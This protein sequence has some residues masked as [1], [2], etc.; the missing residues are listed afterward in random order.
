M[1]NQGK[2]R[3]LGL[4]LVATSLIVL[5]AINAVQLFNPEKRPSLGIFGSDFKFATGSTECFLPIVVLSFGPRSGL[6][7]RVVDVHFDAEN[8]PASCPRRYRFAANAKPFS[9]ESAL[10]FDWRNETESTI[11]RCPTN[12]GSDGKVVNL[13]DIEIDLSPRLQTGASGCLPIVSFEVTTQLISFDRQMTLILAPI[14]FAKTNSQ[15]QKDIDVLSRVVQED[16]QTSQ[17]RGLNAMRIV[18]ADAR[19]T[20]IFNILNI[21]FS[22]LLG[23]GAAAFFEAISVRNPQS[24]RDGP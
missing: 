10:S 16:V 15:K 13:V 21:L 6:H 17:F 4:T 5:L 18:L 22:T 2:L 7:S 9:D 8:Y 24:H 14:P 19:L 23:V 20:A 11:T 3:R 12:L 1:T